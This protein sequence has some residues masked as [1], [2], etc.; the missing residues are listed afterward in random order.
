MLD[1]PLSCRNMNG[2]EFH[3]SLSDRVENSKLHL[4][5]SHINIIL[6]FINF[7]ITESSKI[8]IQLNSVIS[9]SVR[10]TSRL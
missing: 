9:T 1:L 3:P 6:P 2:K 10:A 8:K 4:V 7:N 5:G